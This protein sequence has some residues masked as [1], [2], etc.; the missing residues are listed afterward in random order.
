MQDSIECGSENTRTEGILF[1]SSGVRY[2]QHSPE[3]EGIKCLLHGVS[4]PVF[5][6]KKL[7]INVY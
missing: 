4:S 1:S 3:I 5:N 6:T 7:P 2:M